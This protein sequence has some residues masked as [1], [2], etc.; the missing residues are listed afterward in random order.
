MSNLI[1]KAKDMLSKDKKQDT[2]TYGNDPSYANTNPNIGGAHNQAMRDD[3]GNNPSAPGGYQGVGQQ[4]NY[5]DPAMNTSGGY[6]HPGSSNA[7]PHS[8]NMANKMDP[9]YASSNLA[10]DVAN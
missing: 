4:G 3:Y 5:T 1:N 7:G 8:S 6:N 10:S 9:R 2:T